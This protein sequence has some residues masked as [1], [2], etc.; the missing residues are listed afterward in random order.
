[1]PN[2]RRWRKEGGMFFFTLVTHRRRPLFNV[3]SA[4][5][6]LREA[7]TT[8]RRNHAF[9]LRAMVLLPDHLHM[10]LSLPEGDAGY[11][12]R[13]ALIKRHFT[14]AYLASGG[15]EADGSPSRACHRLRGV[16]QKRFW[17]HTI[18][19]YRDY[20]RHL[21]Y[22]HAN[23][24]K[25]GLVVWPKNWPYS[26]FARFVRLGEYSVDWCGHVTLP[27]GVDIEPDTW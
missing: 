17:E 3:P 2:Y 9:E 7:I 16:W 27:G 13:L 14:I 4:R 12:T 21:D 26:T 23:P 8:V 1:M 11:A 24:V 25:H 20:K 15:T 19:D 22:I 6:L 10:L 5:R 18:R